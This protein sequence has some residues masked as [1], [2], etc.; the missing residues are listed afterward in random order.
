MYRINTH[1]WKHDSFLGEDFFLRFFWRLWW[2]KYPKHI[3]RF[4]PIFFWRDPCPIN[5]PVKKKRRNILGRFEVIIRQACVHAFSNRSKLHPCLRED[6]EIPKT[7]Q[8]FPHNFWGGELYGQIPNFP[9]RWDFIATNRLHHGFQ[10]ISKKN[11]SPHPC[12]ERRIFSDHFF[13]GFSSNLS[14]P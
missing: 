9:P 10:T 11:T 14:H 8:K 2:Q 12:F 4:A 7:Y 5:F 13:L 6:R 3:Q 1:T